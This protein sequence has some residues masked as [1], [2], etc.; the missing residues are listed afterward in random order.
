MTREPGDPPIQVLVVEDDPRVR[1]ALTRFLSACDGF[2]VIGDAATPTTALHLAHHLTPTVALVDVHLPN[3][4]D[5]LNLLRALTNLGIPTI[6]I[7]IHSWQHRNAL[8]AGAHQFLDKQTP[9]DHML[10][11]LR[12]A[13][14]H[15]PQVAPS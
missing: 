2:Q 3:P 10:T 5:G 1:T 15:R 12:H 13:A 7:S 6:A 11:A 4:T 9:P 14:Q 8:A